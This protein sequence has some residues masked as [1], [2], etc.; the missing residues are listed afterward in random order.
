MKDEIQ[1]KKM[2]EDLQIEYKATTED[3]V[4]KCADKEDYNEEYIAQNKIFAQIELLNWI[5]E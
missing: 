5:L 4:N 1:I 2:L 3:I